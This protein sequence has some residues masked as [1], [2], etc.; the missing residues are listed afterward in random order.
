MHVYMSVLEHKAQILPPH[1]VHSKPPIQCAKETPQC[2]YP[3]LYLLLNSL[4]V[5]VG[6]T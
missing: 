3:V 4:S 5:L 6:L 1:L 2:K